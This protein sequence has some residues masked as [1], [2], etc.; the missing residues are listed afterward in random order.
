MDDPR[1]RAFNEKI[2]V[3]IYNFIKYY[4]LR[5]IMRHNK[6]FRARYRLLVFV[7]FCLLRFKLKIIHGDALYSIRDGVK[8]C[9]LCCVTFLLLCTAMTVRFSSRATCV[10]NEKRRRAGDDEASDGDDASDGD[11]DGDANRP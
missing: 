11:G 6:A 9:K 4:V 2:R 10:R 1:L 3:W 5:R 7:S 8:L